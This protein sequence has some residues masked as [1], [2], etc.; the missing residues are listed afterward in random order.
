MSDL[1]RTLEKIKS[2]L[3]IDL[4]EKVINKNQKN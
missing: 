4:E 3:G 1:Y 2:V